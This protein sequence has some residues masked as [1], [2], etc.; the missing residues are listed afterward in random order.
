[1]TFVIQRNITIENS[2]NVPQTTQLCSVILVMPKKVGI[3]A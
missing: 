2:A 3:A 1:M